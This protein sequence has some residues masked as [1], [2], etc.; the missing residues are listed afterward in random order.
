M[1]LTKNYSDQG[2]D[3][4]VVR[5]II[6]ITPEGVILLNGAPL[7]SAS[8]QEKSSASTVEELKVD[9]NALLQKLQA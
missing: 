6:E 7:T 3:R 5:G 2:G 9:F 4:W 1:R 8:F